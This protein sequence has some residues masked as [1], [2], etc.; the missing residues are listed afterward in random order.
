MYDTLNLIKARQKKRQAE[1]TRK[2]FA[3]FLSDFEKRLLIFMCFMMN[4][5]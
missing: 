3:R 2:L 5:S 4:S 1:E